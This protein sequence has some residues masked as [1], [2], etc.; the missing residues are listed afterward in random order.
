MAMD[1]FSIE[2]LMQ[3]AS[4]PYVAAK[5]LGTENINRLSDKQVRNLLVQADKQ[6][7]DE[8]T[9]EGDQ[10]DN[11]VDRAAKRLDRMV[12]A[13]FDFKTNLNEYELLDLHNIGRNKDEIANKIL[14]RTKANHTSLVVALLRH[15]FNRI[16]MAKR[17][18]AVKEKISNDDIDAILN[19]LYYE[20]IDEVIEAIMERKPVLNAQ[21][22]YNIIHY[23]QN[24]KEAIRLLGPENIKKLNINIQEPHEGTWHDLLVAR[25]EKPEQMQKDLADE[26]NKA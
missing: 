6:F 12:D 23:A 9:A 4:D 18:L 21:T 5:K 17:I 11:A 7:R 13:L 1:N 25:A 8:M 22:V 24:K 19:E 16:K 2:S 15:T 3:M 26:M 10:D 14:D 20:G